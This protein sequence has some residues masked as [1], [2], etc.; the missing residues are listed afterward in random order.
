VIRETRLEEVRAFDAIIHNH[1]VTN[2]RVVV[3]NSTQQNKSYATKNEPPLYNHPVTNY[4]VV[5]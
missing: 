2:Y 1:P 4:R 3:W 5:V